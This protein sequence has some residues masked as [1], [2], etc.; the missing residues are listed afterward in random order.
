MS[1]PIF[2]LAQQIAFAQD[3]IAELHRAIANYMHLADE[4]TFGNTRPYYL[5]TASRF[6]HF[7]ADAH[8]S[9]VEMM[10]RLS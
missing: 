10:E 9:M 1:E 3:Y 4:A 2:T 6:Q 8:A 7:A 5:A